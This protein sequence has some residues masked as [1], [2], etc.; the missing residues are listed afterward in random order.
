MKK[1]FE[2]KKNVVIG[3][4]A[5][6]ILSFTIYKLI[7][8]HN[9]FLRVGDMHI[10]RESH[11]AVLLND[12]RVLILSNLVN[13]EIYNPKDKKFKL[14]D[15]MNKAH[16]EFTS[17]L[18]DNGKVLVVGGA[19]E[20]SIISTKAELFDPKTEKFKFSAKLNYPRGYH[21]ATLLKDG[22]V[23]IVGG[24]DKL[25]KP[26]A[27]CEIYNPKTEKFEIGPKLSIPRSEHFSIL[28]KNGNVLILGGGGRDSHNNSPMDIPELYITKDNKFVQ[29]KTTPFSIITFGNPLPVMLNNGDILIPYCIKNK[30]KINFQ[31]F[32]SK[33]LLFEDSLISPNLNV[34]ENEAIALEN[35]SVLFFGGSKKEPWYYSGVKNSFI[36]DS[37][38]KEL[39]NGPN[40]KFARASSTATLLKNGSVLITGGKGN[41][42]NQI[43]KSAELYLP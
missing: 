4:I 14:I 35:G 5:L 34:I 24:K 11:N 3:L 25:N 20:T 8:K 30:E 6:V 22:K 18:L 39:M 21:T 15:G 33:T 7:P 10:P 12:G 40:L 16:G 43:L 28:L 38:L 13:E 1:I 19:K 29:L 36:L 9:V 37:N 32:N 2:N 31:I 17:T 41:L 26:I 27:Y 42:A 23:L